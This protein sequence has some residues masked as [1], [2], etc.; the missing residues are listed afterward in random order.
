MKVELEKLD[1]KELGIANNGFD[2]EELTD[3]IET[4][5]D[6]DFYTN[7]EGYVDDKPF[8]LY[9]VYEDGEER[10]EKV[11]CMNDMYIIYL[12][13][14]NAV[15]V[16]SFVV[17]YY[18]DGIK[19]QLEYSDGE[20]V[21]SRENKEVYEDEKIVNI[22]KIARSNV[23]VKNYLDM[24]FKIDELKE[25]NQ[26]NIKTIGEKTKEEKRKIRELFIKNKMIQSE[27][28]KIEENKSMGE[29]LFNKIQ[30]TIGIEKNDRIR[31]LKN[32]SVNVLNRINKIEKNLMI[33]KSRSNESDFDK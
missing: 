11:L 18:I 4:D 5:N 9:D 3:V 14:G 6:L 27:I 24:Y 7:T 13:N 33:K 30:N 32:R 15:K 20:I 16:N 1:K 12:D 8:V 22:G 29:R 23:F 25:N 21:H 26:R 2:Y 10:L 28:K 17:E 19:E 31:E